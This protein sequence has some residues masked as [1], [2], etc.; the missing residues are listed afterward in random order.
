MRTYFHGTNDAENVLN[1]IIGNGKLRT[2]F[3]LTP[4][5]SVAKNYGGTVIAVEL[6][7]DLTKAHIGMINKDGNFNAMVG[8]GIEVVLNNEAA[9]NE[10]YYNLYDAKVVH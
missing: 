3:H 5:M 6:E 4:D 8:N 1:A 9:V 2:G 7:E 10:L